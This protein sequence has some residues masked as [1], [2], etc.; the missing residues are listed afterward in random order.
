MMRDLA[1]QLGQARRAERSPEMDTPGFLPD[2]HEVASGIR[3]VGALPRFLRH[4][5]TLAEAQAILEQR[6]R[7]RE[8]NL[9]AIV[10]RVLAHDSNPYHQLFSAAGCEYGDV[11]RLVSDEGVE[12]ALHALYR[13]GIYLAVDELKG[14][15]PAVRGSARIEVNT[16]LLRGP[17]STGHYRVRSSGSTGAATSLDIDLEA[18]RD[19]AVDFFLD[20]YAHDGLG[21]EMG[22]C[23]VPGGS[24]LNGLLMHAAFGGRIRRWFCPVAPSA[25]ELPPR[26][27]WSARALRL[28]GWVAQVPMPVPEYVR[29]DDPMPIVRWLDECL[30]G[31]ATPHLRLAPSLAV[32]IC[33]TSDDVGIDIAGAQ[34][35]L[36]GEPI[37]PARRDVIQRAGVHISPMYS[38]VETGRMGG[39]CAAP[40]VSDE[41]HVYRDAYTFVQPGEEAGD[42]SLPPKALLVTTL[43]R[44]VRVPL[45]NSSVG[46]QA[47]FVERSCGC[48]MEQFGWTTH[49]HSIRSFE[50][51]TSGGM[52]FLDSHV[53][54]ALEEALPA[55]F[56]GGPTDFQLIEEETTEGKPRVR[57]L[58]HPRLGPVDEAV[59]VEAFLDAISSGPG[60]ER[61]MGSMWRDAGFVAVERREPEATQF[62]KILHFRSGA[63]RGA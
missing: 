54:K 48:P 43:G 58:V 61:V 46:D 18:I 16:T 38:S 5:L 33:Q 20:Y 42:D 31:G 13:S 8:A 50:K 28:G 2:L 3:F 55:R 47:T 27:P 32:Q 37:T 60:A 49:L 40:E 53:V 45:I 39:G 25:P 26:Y 10:R 62:G 51:L 35:M 41:L 24:A 44:R 6:W 30:R 9:L 7:N 14:R 21:W 19:G 57:L 29:T 22:H 52:T 15:R 63:I 34:F 59:V 1:A 23:S 56:G 4:P 36:G 17:A 11:Q 12:G